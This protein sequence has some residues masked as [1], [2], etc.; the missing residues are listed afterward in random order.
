MREA[1]EIAIDVRKADETVLHDSWLEGE[2]GMK[3]SEAGVELDLN[4]NSADRVS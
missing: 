4:M 3:M 1:A 2:N